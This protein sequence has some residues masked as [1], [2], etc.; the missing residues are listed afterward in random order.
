MDVNMKSRGGEIRNSLASLWALLDRKDHI[1]LVILTG[2]LLIAAL[3]E[4]I[5]VGIVPAFV[6][7]ISVPER[8]FEYPYAG[9]LLRDYGVVNQRQLLLLFTGFLIIIFTTKFGYK[10]F[11]SI[12]QARFLQ[13]LRVRL[14]TELFRAYMY[15]PYSFH[16]Q[17]NPAELMRNA[18]QEVERMIEHVMSPLLILIAQG[19]IGLAIIIF[20]MAVQPLV[21]LTGLGFF[22]I[23]SY[24]FLAM[25]RSRALSYGKQAQKYRGELIKSV[26]QGLG[27]LK[28]ARILGREQSF[29]EKYRYSANKLAQSIRHQFITSQMIPSGLE[30]VA[31]IGLTAIVGL[32]MTL[33]MQTQDILPVLA[34]FAAA[35]LR[36]K[37]VVSQLVSTINILRY[38][39]ITV[40]PVFEDLTYLASQTRGIESSGN[41]KKL[42][43]K[44]AIEIKDVCF[45]Y[46]HAKNKALDHVNLSIPKGASVAFVGETGA[47]KSTLADVLL[48]LIEPD[49]GQVLVDGKDIRLNLRSWQ[50]NIGYIPQSLYLLDDSLRRNIAFGLPDDR[51]DDNQVMEVLKIAQLEEVLSDLPDGLDTLLGDRGIRLSGGQRQRVCI[52][53]ALYN[54]PEVLILDEATSA[55]DNQ[56]E[57]RIVNE[58]E[59]SR[60]DKTLI[61]IAHRLS[62]VEN[63]DCLYLLHKNKISAEGSYIELLDSSESFRMMANT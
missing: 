6:A 45:T 22:A 57:K 42:P 29:V 10:V 59:V 5:G 46:P 39:Y 31:V 17:R 56:T 40:I 26:N 15:A 36:L 27:G 33:G 4:V 61:I 44:K 60:G 25:V 54:D 16:L 55:L 2:I 63:C 8:I 49:S 1:Q 23:A 50:A 24:L 13:N 18:N 12:V 30:L 58:L 53:R 41:I 3:L 43:L 52:A 48:G 37:Q 32:L 19:L 34:L 38:E 9:E 14:S 21:T 11:T 28:E 62:T 20:M 51:I 7:S 35:L 47:G